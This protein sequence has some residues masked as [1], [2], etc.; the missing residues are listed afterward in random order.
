MDIKQ[1]IQE[2]LQ[3]ME[4]FKQQIVDNIE[5][6]PDNPKI[7]RMGES[8]NCFIIRSKDLENNWSPEYYDSKYQAQVI[9]KLIQQ[10]ESLN[11][12]QNMLNEI[13]EKGIYRVSENHRMYFNNQVRDFI[14]QLL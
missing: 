5:N 11:A 2:I 3:Q 12:I 7:K 4:N 9:I 1:T 10:K 8:K 13:V 6:I 14:K